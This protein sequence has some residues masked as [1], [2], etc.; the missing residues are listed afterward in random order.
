MATVTV[1]LFLCQNAV[2]QISFHERAFAESY[3]RES[4]LQVQQLSCGLSDE[5]LNYRP[6]PDAWNIR[7]NVQ[8]L[9]AVEKR[10]FGTIQSMLNE[11]INETAPERID[12]HVIIDRLVIRTA[13]S[14]RFQAP[15]AL[16]PTGNQEDFAAILEEY[17]AGRKATL[18]LFETSIT[19]W[20]DKTAQHPYGHLDVYQWLVF[21]AAHNA[22]H[23]LQMQEILRCIAFDRHVPK[24]GSFTSTFE[25]TAP[26]DKVYEALTTGIDQWWTDLANAAR[27]IG[28]TLVIVADNTR[29]TFIVKDIVPFHHISWSCVDAYL[30]I[31]GIKQKNE[32]V[33]TTFLWR[34]DPIDNGTRLTI[35][36]DGLEPELECY[37]VCAQA[38]HHFFTESLKGYLETG[39][40]SPFRNQAQ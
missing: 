18:R 21:V 23:N 9:I 6:L 24:R 32:W 17:V 19:G 37:Q 36:H 34:M 15:E 35:T 30:D 20:R 1:F 7:D 40:G 31:P 10:V 14:K 38:W 5:E 16:H 8:H 12:D 26:V 22:R 4:M 27:E 33:G 3:L 13:Q 2:S 28:D 29:K 25:T 39:S 11:E